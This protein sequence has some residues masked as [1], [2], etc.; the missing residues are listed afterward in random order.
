MASRLPPD[1]LSDADLVD[2]CNHGD[3]RDGAAAFETLYRRHK[4]FVLRVA[5]R[6]VNDND[7]ALD[8]LQETFSYLLKKFP[9]QGDGL[10]LTAKLTSFLYPVAKNSAISLARKAGRFPA[11]GSVQPDDLPASEAPA[12]SGIPAL[13]KE[14]PEQ[15]REVITLRFVDDLSLNEIAELLD[16]PL[17]T[18]KSRLH[19]GIKQLRESPDTK[20]F[21]DP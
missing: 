10:T 9:P 13:L 16:I 18:V 3:A 14:L 20:K 4:D 1:R 19:L 7:A 21:F 5:L 17:G 15:Q 2:V 12:A 11:S 6:Y 8:A